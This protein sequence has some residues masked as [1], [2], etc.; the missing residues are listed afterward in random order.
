MPSSRLVSRYWYGS[1]QDIE[2]CCSIWVTK[3]LIPYEAGIQK[4]IDQI[5]PALQT[6]IDQGKKPS[7]VEAALVNALR[8]M[9]E[10]LA[11]VPHKRRGYLPPDFREVW[12]LSTDDEGKAVLGEEAP[13]RKIDTDQSASPPRKTKK[14]KKKGRW[15]LQTAVFS[16]MGMEKGNGIAE[17]SPEDTRDE[18]S[19]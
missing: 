2:N 11:K 12:E 8:E 4:K 5:P 16:T 7:G 19:V 3:N 13:K 9:K 6:K 17:K 18:I 15:N 10:D 1:S 14:Q